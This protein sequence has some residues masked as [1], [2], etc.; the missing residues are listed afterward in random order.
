[1]K[2]TADF[3][4]YTGKIIKPMHAAGQPPFVGRVFKWT[5]YFTQAGIPYS[6]LHD[7]GG[8]FG[9]NLFV[10]IPNIF[11]DFDA[12]ETKEESYDFA[13]TD[14][15]IKNLVEAGVEPFFRLGVTIENGYLVKAYRIYPPKDFKK[16]ARIWEHIIR[17][18]N[19]GWANGFHY[20]ITYWE[21]WNEPDSCFDKPR[22]DG[23]GMWLGTKEQYFE[24]YEITS[25][26]LKTCFGDSIK[27]GGYASIGFCSAKKFPNQEVVENADNAEDFWLE[28][29]HSFFK[30]IT[31]DE[32]K[33]PLDFFSWHCYDDVKTI[34]YYSSYCRK[35]LQK[36]GLGDVPDFLNEWNPNPAHLKIKDKDNCAIAAHV[37][38]VM[39]SMQKGTTQMLNFYDSRIAVSAY[40]GMFNPETREPYKTYYAFS[41]FNKAYKLKNEIETSSDNENVYVCGAAND[42]KAVLLIANINGQDMEADLDINGVCTDDVD[43]LMIDDIYRYTDTGKIIKDGK[44]TLPAN[45]CVE[46]RFLR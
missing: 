9:G 42:K 15:L 27:V 43:I 26:H 1:M 45:S 46:I 37:F 20:N 23:M 18:Y 2:I 19:E 3:N 34:E 21:I 4:K 10:D 32:H 24:M 35:M 16:W 7:V 41:S 40:C 13:Y 28:F 17:H 33:C 25:K 12:D 39:L 8:M 36:Y 22:M 14:I 6:R 11:R 44:L 29:M 30:Y 31:S 38:A 5:H